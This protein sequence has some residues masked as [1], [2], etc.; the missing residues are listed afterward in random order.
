MVVMVVVGRRATVVG[1]RVTVAGWGVEV[2]VG[3][4]VAVEGSVPA[5]G[6]VREGVGVGMGVW[7]GR[8]RRGV[9]REGVSCVGRDGWIEEGRGRCMI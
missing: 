9:S 7:G 2:G 8:G 5:V 4:G 1:G 6:V 3:M